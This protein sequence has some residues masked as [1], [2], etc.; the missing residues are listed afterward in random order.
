MKE[1]LLKQLKLMTE[2]SKIQF[3]FQQKIG[4]IQTDILENL[5]KQIELLS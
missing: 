2:L 4:K 3:E 1:L 5:Q